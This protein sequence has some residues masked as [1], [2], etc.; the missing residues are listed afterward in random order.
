MGTKLE[1]EW[2]GCGLEMKEDVVDIGIEGQCLTELVKRYCIIHGTYGKLKK[3]SKVKE[4][5]LYG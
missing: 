1:C 2:K 3:Y 4:A 5:D